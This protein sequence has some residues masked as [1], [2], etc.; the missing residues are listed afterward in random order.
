MLPSMSA[1]WR[2]RCTSRWIRV[3]SGVRPSGV[4]LLH[5]RCAVCLEGCEGAEIRGDTQRSL[6]R[7]RVLLTEELDQYSERAGLRSK[8]VEC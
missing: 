8:G 3:T 6:R 4:V 7:V 2:K 1:E 5:R